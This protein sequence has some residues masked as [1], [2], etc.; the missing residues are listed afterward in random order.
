M[1]VLIV[2]SGAMGSRYG[3]ALHKGGAEVVLFDVNK[4]H[5]KAISE[6]GLMVHS[7]GEARTY[8]IAATSDIQKV[9]AFDYAF[10]FT[11]AIHTISAMETVA[12]AL[13]DSTI[14]VTLQN[15]MG[16]VE[17][18]RKLAPKSPIIAGT[19]NYAAALLGPGQLE[20][21]GSGITKVQLVHGSDS[22]IAEELAKVLEAGGIHV[23]VVNDIEYY[24][25]AKVAFN[26]AL[27]TVTAL[28]GLSVGDVGAAPES[29]DMVFRIAKDVAKVARSKGINLSDEEACDSIRS[30]MDPKMSSGHHPSMLQ[31]VMARRKTEVDC[32]CGKVLEAGASTGA[33]TPYLKSAYSLI[34]AIESNYSK[35]VF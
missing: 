14:I 31:D 13:R 4:E 27:N 18:L 16:N 12:P 2:G 3:V 20:A 8:K 10:V 29:L 33:E 21:N 5:T 1:R 19:T 28:T 30:V 26:A 9:G 17:T 23:D 7:D 24:I 25:W 6:N 22:K 15:G 35:R 34:K 11:K 32:I